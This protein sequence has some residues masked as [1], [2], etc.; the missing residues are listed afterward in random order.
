MEVQGLNG[1]TLAFIGDAIMSLKVREYLVELGYQRPNDLQKRSV[2]YVSA[3]AQAN[4]LSFLL[5]EGFFTESEITIIKRGRNSKSDSIAKN[6]DVV[7]Y[8][9][10]TGFEA[11]WGYL[12]LTNQHDRL[13]ELWE[14]VKMIEEK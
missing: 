10:S 11:L 8:R 1:T 2:R 9:M 6:A 14:K 4:F 3:K 5:E 12:Y 7:T 13:Q